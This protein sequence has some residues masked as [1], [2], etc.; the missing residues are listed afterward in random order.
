MSSYDLMNNPREGRENMRDTI[1]IQ[2]LY[3]LLT[4]LYWLAV[5]LPIALLVL[6]VQSRGLS[7]FQLSLLFGLHALTVFLLEVP[8]GGL[9]DLVGRKKVTI[10]SSLLMILG[11]G[12]FLVSFSFPLLLLGGVVYGI[13]RALASGALDAWFIDEVQAVEPEVDIH[14]LLARGGVITLGGLATGTLLG[15]ILPSLVP[16]LP[17]EG[18]AILTPFSS[19]LL[20][21]IVV[22][23]V[24]FL[25]LVWLVEE[26][27]RR[28]TGR[29]LRHIAAG[30]PAFV[31]AAVGVGRESVVIRALLLASF[32]TGFAMF[33]LENFW[34]PH[35]ATLLGGSQG[36]S[37]V[38]GGIMTGNFLL[39]AVG[40][41][42]SLPLA[43]RLG[44]R[45]GLVAGIAELSRGTFLLLL[46]L[47]SDW[48]TA[49]GL[50]WIIYLG[51]GVVEAPAATLFNLE[52]PADYRSSLLSIRSMC[53][54]LGLF[55]G[56]LGL[57]LVAEYVSIEAAWAIAGGCLLLLFLPYWQIDRPL[58]DRPPEKEG[59]RE[60]LTP[61]EEGN[62]AG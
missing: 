11:F 61:R 31:R 2:R 51:M 36:N 13:S 26:R 21:S 24:R 49:A 17:P 44:G 8:T 58:A 50:F 52:V 22:Q 48:L 27:P 60:A 43:R 20:A 47:Q 42:L 57:G 12:I 1:T 30:V 5:A 19:T 35:F 41:L 16:F 45:L 46:V 32:G 6:I 3:Y 38:F 56:S 29:G 4:F 10:W 7:L 34:Q 40:N 23:S 33:S 53:T 25:L 18:S 28:T 39:A 54:Y 59:A 37:V 62:H 15:G 14:P 55:A 9:A